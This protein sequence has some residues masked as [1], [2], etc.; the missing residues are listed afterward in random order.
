MTNLLPVSQILR[1]TWLCVFAGCANPERA[2]DEDDGFK[3]TTYCF[4]ITV[5][6]EVD[7]REACV[8]A[9]SMTL[10][11]YVGASERISIHLK[12]IYHCT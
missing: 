11:S 5:C 6:E 7:G 10:P 1:A 3:I 12:F 9:S 8:S 4:F 2:Q